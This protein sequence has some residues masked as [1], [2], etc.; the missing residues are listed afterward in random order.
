MRVRGRGRGRGRGRSR[1]R[2]RVRVRVRVRVSWGGSG[3]RYVV[4]A[5]GR[6]QREGRS[7]RTRARVHHRAFGPSQAGGP[8]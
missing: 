5:P 7:W 8:A 6:D 2:R 4:E 1:G 3:Q